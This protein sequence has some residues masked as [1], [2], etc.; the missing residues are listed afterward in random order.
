[1]PGAGPMRPAA[2]GVFLIGVI[3]MAAITLHA[4]SVSVL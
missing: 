2:F 1:M 4:A 3:A